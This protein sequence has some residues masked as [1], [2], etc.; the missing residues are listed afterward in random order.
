MIT[1]SLSHRTVTTI[2]H[3]SV[4]LHGNKRVIWPHGNIPRNHS[5]RSN[6]ALTLDIV[7]LWI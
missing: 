3:K 7:G 6:L 1:M 2:Q 4:V 5:V